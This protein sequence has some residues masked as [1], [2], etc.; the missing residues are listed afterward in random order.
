M[1][2]EVREVEVERRRAMRARWE[3]MS[4]EERQEAMGRMRGQFEEWRQS[5]QVELPQITLD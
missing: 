2:A 3:T 4:D 5:G 1:P